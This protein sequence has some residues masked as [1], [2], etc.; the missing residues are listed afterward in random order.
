M[1][2]MYEAPNRIRNKH[3]MKLSQTKSGVVVV[4]C[5]GQHV[6]VACGGTGKLGQFF[7]CPRHA[8]TVACDWTGSVLCVVQ[9]SIPIGIGTPAED[10]RVKYPERGY[11]FTRVKW[12]EIQHHDFVVLMHKEGVWGPGEDKGL[13]R[14]DGW[15]IVYPQ[16]RAGERSL[17][18]DES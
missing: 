7:K 11:G 1:R 15:K 17:V 14:Q 6:C 5:T 16:D 9:D 8:E 18:Y 13:Y 3:T 10:I 12:A 4:K 2:G